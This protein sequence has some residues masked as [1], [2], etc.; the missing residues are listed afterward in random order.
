MET[1]DG[2]IQ[3][4]SKDIL[5]MYCLLIYPISILHIGIRNEIKLL[6]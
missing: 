6:I 1:G 4:H 2:K 5:G 3:Y